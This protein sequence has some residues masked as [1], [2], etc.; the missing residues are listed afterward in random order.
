[1]NV[2]IV[3]DHEENLYLLETIL[4]G[5]GHDVQTASNGAEA[6]EKLKAGGFELIISDILMP[7]M[8]GFQFC[9]IVKADATLRH[10]PFIF[11]T[12]TYTGPQDEAL[13]MKIG[14]DRFIQ[15]PC[16]PDVI[17][18]AVED[19]MVAARDT[20]N[21]STPEPPKE[22]EILKLYNERLV[23]KL[24]QKMLQAE[25][26]IQSRQ[27]AEEALRISNNRLL[28]ALASADIGLWD[29]NLET[30]EAWF[31]PEWK[32]QIGYDDHEIPNRYEEWEE[33]LHPEDHPRILAEVD[34]Y[35]QGRRPD[36]HVEF[37]LRHKDGS[38]RWIAASGKLIS[39]T[40]KRYMRLMGCHVDITERKRAEDERERLM[41]AIEQ[42]GEVVFI[43]DPDGI[44]QYVNP[45]FETVT[46]YTYEE[47]VG[48]NPS[49]L[50][51]SGKQ[52]QAFYQDLWGTITAGKTWKG[53]IINKRKDGKLFTE[54]ATISP[55]CDA[56]GRV[57]NYVGVK[58]DITEHL[59]LEAQLFQA[60]KM[61]SV[62]RLAG[63]VAHDYNN[64]LSVIL[65]Y[66]ELSL[67]KVN[68]GDPLRDN[69]QEILKAAR[70]STGITRQL[71]AFA[72]KQAIE[73]QVVDLN[74]IV[75]GGG[76]MLH[77]LVGEN[78]ALDWRPATDLW[79]VMMDPSQVDQLLVNLCVNA[80]DAIADVG[81]VTIETG[82]VV[83]DEEYCSYHAGF[84]PGEF[85][86]LAI[87]DDGIGMDRETLDK[88]F[89]PFFTTKGIGKGTGLGLAT[90]YGIVKQNNGFI[91]I[92]SEP[93]EGT[94]FKIF[95][96]R[97]SGAA[98]KV[99][100]ESAAEIPK[101]RGE[102]ILVV[103]D[104]FSILKLANR[105][106]D[107]LGYNVLTAK[108]PGEAMS[109]VDK[110]AGEI[111]LLI[112]DMVMPEM[113]GRDLADRLHAL[114]PEIK[115]LFMSGYAANITTRN[116]VL[117]EGVHF[118]QKPFS[119]KDLAVKVRGALDC[120]VP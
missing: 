50:L 95:L 112:T 5:G 58:R 87:S 4:K 97:H 16:E 25:R 76:K 81:K 42:A 38:Y 85:A 103:E 6:L 83:F 26:E 114:Y 13:A 40:D 68:Q 101:G 82:N 107:G 92:Y 12:A 27:E 99:R 118:I 10:I 63:G 106:L 72:H 35:L 66:T 48:E 84:V 80:R 100:V 52:D 108:T 64:M 53:R 39:G 105:I 19:A 90:V 3:D 98:K 67:A 120:A 110:H 115:T 56:A 70:R 49:T 69:L 65:G 78:I 116:D 8:D 73:P 86:L 44:I 51:K 7:V 34:D 32:R 43:T 1:V 75:E 71:L 23:R 22:E 47:A 28:L 62:G 117:K 91:N 93:G 11:Y 14:A 104:E 30:N 88:I 102:T 57:V 77:W 61:E 45:V 17:M 20:D 60:Q 9:R 18:K 94:I 31:S 24:E 21:A 111:N 37:R 2:L 96:P 33:R 36:F 54:D 113:N 55:V 29:L 46:G 79:P 15:K 59:Q 89:E 74:E 119:R 109:L 41:A